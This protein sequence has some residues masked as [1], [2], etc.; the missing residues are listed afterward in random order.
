MVRPFFLSL[1]WATT[2]AAFSPAIE[3]IVFKSSVTGK[4]VEFY[5]VAPE[6]PAPWPILVLIHPHQEWPNKV[7]AKA[8]VENGVL[9]EWA[10]KGFLTVAPSQPGYGGSEGPADFCG[11]HTQRS[12]RD[13]LTHF[14]Q[15][16]ESSQ[17]TFL[18][19]GSR[20]AVVAALVA[21][22]E[23]SLSGVVLKSG[24]YDLESEYRSYSWINPIKWTMIWE[25]GWK[26]A[27]ALR[28][29]SALQVA[30]QIR[31]PLLV[32]HGSHDDRASL[33][34]AKTFVQRVNQ[35]GGHA[36]LKVL[37]SEHVIP[38]REISPLMETFL[39]SHK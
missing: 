1:L 16:P 17:R 23:P 37:E 20:G 2:A 4:S 30:D 19:G 15:K 13:V 21:A 33:A 38:M 24:A 3:K 34:D 7:G 5:S 31:A 14:R 22:Q 11:P 25:L 32:I 26:P 18:Y 8:F 35:S 9:G 29:R 28:E 12:M 27:A 39:H 6:T 36:E 10:K